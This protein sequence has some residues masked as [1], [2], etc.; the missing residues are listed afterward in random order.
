MHLKPLL[1][2]AAMSMAIAG[3]TAPPQTLVTQVTQTTPSGVPPRVMLDVQGLGKAEVKASRLTDLPEQLFITD[4]YTIFE[5]NGVGQAFFIVPKGTP[6]P[7]SAS[8]NF[9]WLKANGDPATSYDWTS[10]SDYTHT[11]HNITSASRNPAWLKARFEGEGYAADGVIESRDGELHITHALGDATG[12]NLK[13]VLTLRPEAPTELVF[14]TWIGNTMY[15]LA[16]VAMGSMATSAYGS[17][18]SYQ[19]ELDLSVTSQDDV[20]LDG[21]NR[22]NFKLRNL[23]ATP[24]LY[25]GERPTLALEA[26]GNGQY[27]VRVGFWHATRPETVSIDLALRNTPFVRDVEY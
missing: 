20:P 11:Y 17:Y 1:A 23:E 7:E 3:C 25:G 24:N 5:D 18:T 9:G 27:T 2:I 21:L 15:P 19:L 22:E 16:G 26:R 14:A 10:A 4:L 13:P 8:T 6:A 12:K